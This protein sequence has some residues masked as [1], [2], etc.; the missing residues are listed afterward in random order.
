MGGYGYGGETGEGGVDELWWAWEYGEEEREGWVWEDGEGSGGREEGVESGCQRGREE[1]RRFRLGGY[2]VPCHVLERRL[3]DTTARVWFCKWG[4]RSGN[5]CWELSSQY[6]FAWF[7][8]HASTH[9]PVASRMD[10]C[11]C[12]FGGITLYQ[13]AQWEAEDRVSRVAGSLY[14]RAM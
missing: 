1:R 2:K 3:L 9:Q 8:R 10:S 5:A 13:K 12:G 14:A 11:Y 7:G 6:E 4:A